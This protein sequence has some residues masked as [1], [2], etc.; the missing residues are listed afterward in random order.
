V[1]ELQGACWSRT[2]RRST[3]IATFASD[4]LVSSALLLHGRTWWTGERVRGAGSG[5]IVAAI[6]LGMWN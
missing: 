2:D 1:L 6:T 4:E 5:A 3:L